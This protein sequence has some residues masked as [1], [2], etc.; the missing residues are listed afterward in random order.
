MSVNAGPNVVEDDLVFALDAANSRSYSGTGTTWS[1]LSGNGNHFTLTNSPTHNSAGYFNLGG[2]NEH[3]ISS[4]TV[5]LSAVDAV[6]VEMAL[7][8]NDSVTGMAF[9][10][11]SNWNS[12]AGGFG[13]FPN[14]VG[15]ATYIASTHHTNALNFNPF[16]FTYANNITDIFIVSLSWTWLNR[17]QTA[18]VN[19]QAITNTSQI[20]QATS[21]FSNDYFYIGSRGGTS[22][23]NNCKVYYCKMYNR[24]L[25]AAEVA[26]NF[27]AT[28]SRYGI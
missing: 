16:N 12:Q 21:T 23:F 6:T 9:E 5:D 10:H 3:I 8:K 14:S 25:T 13:L 11:T 22:L 7:A 17:V 19:G 28:R 18:Y 26:Q 1:D 20:G 2:T 15:S 27:N 24:A 4:S